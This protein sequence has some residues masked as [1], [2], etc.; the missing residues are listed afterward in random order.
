MRDMT[1]SKAGR[2]YLALVGVAAGI[3][4]GVG[5]TAAV[6]A[7]H[8]G[9]QTLVAHQAGTIAPGL[10]Y[11]IPT[12]FQLFKSSNPAANGGHPASYAW[13]VTTLPDGTVA[14]SDI[15][16]NRVLHYDES[17]NLLG[18]LFTTNGK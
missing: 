6:Q 16:N 9:Q 1:M 8:G 3:I 13:G 2:R 15:F 11:T 12:P 4:S 18:V 7:S 17:G 10:N 5:G 14:V